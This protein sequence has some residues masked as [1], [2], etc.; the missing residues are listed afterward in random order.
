M[1][2]ATSFGGACPWWV[3]PLGQQGASEISGFPGSRRAALASSYGPWQFCQ[4]VS[5]DV[6][7]G[8]G[9]GS[10]TVVHG[11]KWPISNWVEM[12]VSSAAHGMMFCGRAVLYSG[13]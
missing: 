10:V 2:P 6:P 7:E 5:V 12:L 9:I 11:S 3:Y 4:I 1:H 13:W 8:S